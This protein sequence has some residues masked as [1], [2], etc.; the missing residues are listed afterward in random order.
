MIVMGSCSNDSEKSVAGPSKASG[1]T[2]DR[3]RRK[4]LLLGVVRPVDAVRHAL[5]LR[6]RLLVRSIVRCRSTTSVRSRR[7]EREDRLAGRVD[8]RTSGEASDGGEGG[9]RKGRLL[10]VVLHR[11]AVPGLL[12]LRRLHSRVVVWVREVR[13]RR[14]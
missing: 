8:G 13:L 11:Y 1:R 14:A 7:S 4:P 2:T 6:V 5:P 12:H 9:R 3:V 10:L